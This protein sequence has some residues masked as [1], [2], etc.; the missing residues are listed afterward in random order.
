M[1]SKVGDQRL[2][3]PGSRFLFPLPL[4]SYLFFSFSLYIYT[5]FVKN[6]TQMIFIKT[7]NPVTIAYHFFKKVQQKYNLREENLLTDTE[8]EKV[9]Q[10]ISFFE[11]IV[12]SHN[13]IIETE[14]KLDLSEDENA[15]ED[16][17]ENVSEGED[18]N[19]SES[20]YSNASDSE[21][22]ETLREM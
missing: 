13:L 21:A 2:W 9:T 20:E 6:I 12:S 11:E 14:Y 5:L 18:D 15:S 16:K 8:N 19:T 7:I 3:D 4:C 10:L 1:G 22:L 17:N